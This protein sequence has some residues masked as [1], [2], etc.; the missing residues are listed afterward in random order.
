MIVMDGSQGEGGG[1]ILRTALALSVVTGTAFRA[2][3]I[4]AGRARPG[5]LRQHLA[6]V[7]A[8][9]AIGDAD[10]G[11]DDIGS[12]AITFRPRR[13]VA[14]AHAFAVGSAGSALL[15]FQTVL[16]ALLRAREAAALVFEGGTHNPMAP[17]FDF[18][19]Q[20]FLPQLARTGA[21]IAARLERPGFYPAGGGRVHVTVDPPGPAAPLHLVDRGATLRLHARAV[22]A[23]VPSRVAHRE[24]HVIGQK[25]GIGK[26]DRE[27]VELDPSFGPG[28][29]LMIAI[30]SE[31]VTEV[32]TAFGEKGRR[33][34]RVAEMAANDAAAYL[35][36][37]APVG[38]HLADQLLV[39]MALAAGGAFRTGALS[40]HAV[41]QI[42]VMRT[43]LGDLV[44]VRPADDGTVTV[45]VTPA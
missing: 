41:T 13:T 30:E 4:R 35:A 6:A 42:D 15:V 23:A 40:S 37:G 1:Q 14:G 28:N 43:F 9:R 8:A 34:E 26:D 5:L 45:H 32:I 31:H 2:E 19:E 33:A 24:L 22:V 29:A 27:A 3:K 20:T 10:V 18:V 17:P 21:R 7:R 12:T 39:P 25:L 36:H 44:V 38:E 16:P 11:G